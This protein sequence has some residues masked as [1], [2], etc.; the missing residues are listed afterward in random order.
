MDDVKIKE[1][2]RKS[3]AEIAKKKSSCCSPSCC[4]N[5]VNLEKSYKKLGYVEEELKSV[6]EDVFS[7]GCGNPVTSASLKEGE[8]VLELGSG[9][10]LDRFLASKRVGEKGRV[11]GVDMTPEMVDRARKAARKGNYGNVEFRLGK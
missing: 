6:P 5:S 9:S 2:V 7:L 8:I 10:G 1:N 11:I 4:Q 3:Y